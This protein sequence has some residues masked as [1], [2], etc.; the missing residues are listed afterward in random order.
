MLRPF[1]SISIATLLVVG[2]GGEQSPTPSPPPE[3]DGGGNTIAL[4]PSTTYQTITGWEVPVIS[5]VH[6]YDA[7]VPFMG[8]IMDQAANDLG[9]NM[10]SV[11]TTSGDENPSD[12]CQLQY[13]NRTI[14]EGVFVDTCLYNSVNDND[15]PFVINPA[16]FHF[17]ILDWQ[18][19]NLLLPLKRSVEARGEKLYVLLRYVDFRSSPFEHYQNPE[20]YAELM[21]VVF[22][23]INAKYGFVPN[24]IDVM[25]EPDQVPG[26]GATEMGRVI[27]RAGA[28]L[29]GLG[30]RPD[31]V[32]PSTVNKAAAIS[33]FDAMM[34]V[35]DAARYL[36]DLSWHCYSDTGSNTSAAIG[37][38]AVQYGV[39][40]SM[41]EC[42][43]TSNT[44]LMLHQELKASRNASW[45]LGVINGVNGYY[46]VSGSGQVTLRPKAKHIRQYY[47]YIRAGAKRIDATTTNSAFDPVAFVNTDGR[48]VVVVKAT[49]GGSFTV[50][51]LPAGS[52]GIFYTTGPD[53]LT[54]S[55]YDVNLPD[56]TISQGRGLTTSIPGA[57]AITV[58][59]KS[60]GATTRAAEATTAF[61]PTTSGLKSDGPTAGI[62]PSKFETTTRDG[63]RLRLEPIVGAIADPVDLAFTPDGRLLVAEREGRIRIVRDGRLLTSPALAF[64][65]PGDAREEFLALAVDPRF[66]RTHY[67]YT[68]STTCPGSPPCPVFR[69]ARFREAWDSLA[70][71]VILLDGIASTPGSP[72]A[73][74][75]FGPDGKLYVAFDDGGV[76]RLAGDLSSVNGKVLRLN[77]DGTTPDDQVGGNPLF[78]YSYHS[79]RGLEWHPTAKTLWLADRESTG[80]S[81]LNVVASGDGPRKR[82]ALRA[83]IAL[84]QDSPPSSLAFYRG[85]GMAMVD[86]LLIASE[87]GRQLLRLRLDPGEPARILTTERL[88]HDE[89]GGIK[90]VSVGPD[91]A[92]YFGT[93]NA[94]GKLVPDR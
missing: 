60:G 43:T 15:N 16:G 56:Q 77:P 89:L 39:R 93:A 53:G 18:I 65:K 48:T 70:D 45:Q 76:A 9:I 72:A 68:I 20:E 41:T 5:T 7:I 66:D 21:Q 52:Y 86:N 46:E 69:L 79:P 13:L 22:D 14:S 67:V 24:G 23:H 42:W 85:N 28:R 11:G 29:A 88:L 83:A 30:W 31:F 25:N 87:Q 55:N 51:N 47:K 26:W 92:I 35:P 12:A 27:A 78:S 91:G 33:Y 84:P 38:K 64:E 57:G 90:V 32:A 44:Y 34:A 73:A 1:L 61:D 80:T 4:N 54:V 2:C 17:P 75:R 40:T 71:R 3:P 50:T 74:L 37:A 82:G 81:R 62:W 94:L 59:A 6:D 8:S 49:T 58:Y 19:D 36:N 10:I 63:V